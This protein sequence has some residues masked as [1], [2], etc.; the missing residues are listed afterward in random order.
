MWCCKRM[1]VISLVLL[2][3]ACLL[4]SVAGAQDISVGDQ[5]TFV[6]RL[7][8]DGT[9]K[10]IP[11]H[12][13]VGER[14]VSDRLP[15]GSRA[16]VVTL[17]PAN[18]ANW[19]EVQAGAV[20]GWVISKY[21][22]SVQAGGAAAATQYRVGCWNLEHFRTGATRGFPENTRGGPTIPERTNAQIQEI[23]NTI[24]QDLNVRFLVLNEINGRTGQDADGD[25]IPV[26]D[27]LDALLGHMPNTW[28]YVI[29][30]SGNHQR[31][32][33]LY[34]TQFVQVNEVQEFVVA[35]RRIQRKD[36]FDR[37][38]LAAHITFL[39]NGVAR[40]DLLVVGVHLAS[41]QGNNRNHD[42]AMDVLLNRIALSQ[43]AGELGGTDEDDILILGDF[44]ANMFRLPAEDF[45]V[46]MDEDDG[47]WDVLADADYPATRLS[48]NPLQQH[49]S[50]IDYIIAS[51]FITG[52]AGLSG[53]ELV[54][55]SLTVHE[56]L[57]TAQGSADN[58]R[59]DLSDHLPVTVGVQ[60][61]ADT[62]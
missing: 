4:V 27:E 10:G 55:T 17:G 36:I 57:I 21:F 37:D 14:V 3:L 7:R 16:T 60:V 5:V 47:P 19:F 40:N 56:A 28:E 1:T 31:I 23:A 43:A 58:F 26:S 51:R 12:P 48:G 29:S 9:D 45:F 33:F 38:P 62:D 24:T 22:G 49:T 30:W 46:E 6:Q 20:Q 59:R 35:P 41:G 52:N 50:Q 42:E 18:R 34:D 25:N 32:A 8:D 15:S 13:A 61:G 39:E 44:N 2:L 54:A 53:E 11:L